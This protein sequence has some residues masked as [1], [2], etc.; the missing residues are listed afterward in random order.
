MM[1]SNY[2]TSVE[3]PSPD[4]I[5]VATMAYATEIAMG[6][7][8]YGTLVLSNGMKFH[9]CSPSIVWSDDSQYL[10]A[11]QNHWKLGRG[12]FRLLFIRVETREF[13]FGGEV[14]PCPEL[15]QF[16]DGIVTGS[17]YRTRFQV[18]VRDVVWQPWKR[19]RAWWRFW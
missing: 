5:H 16:T 3:L 7:P 19:R 18:D 10:A 9:L 8:T 12:G 4:G 17:A 13:G 11:P 6:A 14:Y 2:A 15:E 1:I